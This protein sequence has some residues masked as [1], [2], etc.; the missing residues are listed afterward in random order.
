MKFTGRH[1]AGYFSSIAILLI[2]LLIMSFSTGF[3]QGN[4][5]HM[6]Y[7]PGISKFHSSLINGQIADKSNH[8][9]KIARNEDKRLIEKTLDDTT[10][11]ENRVIS[12]VE[13]RNQDLFLLKLKLKD[14]DQ[15]IAISV[16][17][18]LGKEVLSKH[19]VFDGYPYKDS[20][21]AYE[22]NA[23]TLPNGIY[24]CVVQGGNFRL[25]AKFIVSR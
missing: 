6:M 15:R 7:F 23:S 9:T 16:Y 8:G 5:T 10:S 25:A 20:E 13:V 11:K 14:Y 12:L 4:Q 21:F 19:E 2:M 3:S 22:I 18:M 1:K 17:N 24:L